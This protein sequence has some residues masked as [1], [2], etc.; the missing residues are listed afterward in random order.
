MRVRACTMRCRCHSSCR[1]SRFSQLGTQICGNRSS[2]SNCRKLQAVAL[3]EGLRCKKGLWREQGR[4]Q[5]ESFRLAPWASRRRQD[6]LG[7]AGPSE[8]DDRRTEPG[9]R[10]R[11]GEVSGGTALDEPSRS[12]S[13]DRTGFWVDHGESGSV[14]V[15]EADRKLSGTGAVG[16]L[17]W[18][19]AATGA[20]HQT[21]WRKGWDY[22]QVVKFGWHAGRL[23]TGDGVP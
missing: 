4:E 13:A 12:G 18:Q 20:Y 22:E 1:R 17:E 21:V 10:A 5:L 11:S 3:N 9:D 8:S 2:T 19:W 23:G 7:F 16:G 14:S 6:L 15:W